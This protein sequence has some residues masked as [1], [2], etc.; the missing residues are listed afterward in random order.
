M[1]IFLDPTIWLGLLTLI[2]LE[3]V[4]GIDNLVFIAILAQKLPQHQRRT[5]IRV[6][7]MAALGMR[8]VLL[9]SISWLATLTDPLFDVFGKSFSGRDLIMLVGGLFLL[10]KATGEIH[11]RLEGQTHG[12]SKSKLKAG[13]GLVVTQ[14]IILDA[15]FSLDAVITAVG[16]SDHLPVM[17]AAVAISIV[18]MIVVS[19]PL[20]KFVNNH[21]TIVMLCLGFL[22]MVGFSLVAEGFGVHIPKGYLYA[23]I[24][25]SIIIE[26]FNQFAHAKLRRRYADAE[27]NDMRQRT[28][29]M[30]LRVL[31]ATDSG[32][33]NNSQELGVLLH[34]ASQE[35]ILTTTEKSLLR[36][37]LNLSQRPINTIMTPRVDIEWLDIDDTEEGIRRQ[38]SETTRSQLLVG[39]GDIDTALGVIHREDFIP[40]LVKNNKLPAISKVMVE[41]QFMHE[42]MSVLKS[43]EIFKVHRTDMAVVID[44]F[45][46]VQGIVTHH[47]L[48]EAIAG[49][50][51]ESD[52]TNDQLEILAQDDG[53]YII[54]GRASIYDVQTQIGIDYQPDGHFATV[55]GFILHEF[56]R[57]PEAGEE[58]EWQNW[59]LKI[60]RTEGKRIDKILMTRVD[61]GEQD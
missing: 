31:G 33:G 54:D 6:G 36:G 28:A 25:F 21:P 46:S 23:A 2:L 39:R 14:I 29:D 61:D 8:C 42:G 34:Q 59:K 47:D 26:A 40:Q 1:E 12:A 56:A 44:E 51:P 5:A 43:L 57:I 7:L 38:I 19:E 16:M 18:L 10:H 27:P 30:V 17:I 32:E 53:S 60:L 15:V 4:L 48:L 37:V 41:P 3:L 24:G 11:T 49:E 22:L 35:D 13:F 55:A 50:F 20:T 58:L 45:G 9:A 52:E